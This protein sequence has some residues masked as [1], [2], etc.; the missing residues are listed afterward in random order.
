MYMFA[1]VLVF[2]DGIERVVVFTD[3]K[4]LLYFISCN[5]FILPALLKTDGVYMASALKQAFHVPCSSELLI[6]TLSQ[7]VS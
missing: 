7:L 2:Q 6:L 5:C 4:L 3:L 1:T